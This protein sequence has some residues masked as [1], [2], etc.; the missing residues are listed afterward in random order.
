MALYASTLKALEQKCSKE[1]FLKKPIYAGASIVANKIRANIRALPSEPF[2]HL[3]PGEVFQSVPEGQKRAL[4]EEFGLSPVQ[5]D[6]NG[7]IHTK[8]GFDGYAPWETESYP[9]GVP[10]PLLAR[11]IESGSSVRIKHPFIRPALDS[12][13][14]KAIRAMDEALRK[15]LEEFIKK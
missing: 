2:R 13:R 10:T 9:S 15:E 8:A 4:E 14:R 1:Q 5:A 11:A 7:F 6:R 3:K 12:E